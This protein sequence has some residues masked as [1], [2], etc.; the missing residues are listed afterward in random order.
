[1]SFPIDEPIET[2]PKDGTVILGHRNGQYLE[3]PMRWSATGWQTCGA[4]KH[5]CLKFG[6]V[7]REPTEWSRKP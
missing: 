3:W 7:V 6:E 5:A 1:M 4:P 2:A